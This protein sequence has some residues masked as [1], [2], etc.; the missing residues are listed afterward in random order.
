MKVYHQI[1]GLKDY[2][3]IRFYMPENHEF[4]SDI[5]KNRLEGLSNNRAENPIYKKMI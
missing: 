2:F 1:N 4:K 5:P 3:E